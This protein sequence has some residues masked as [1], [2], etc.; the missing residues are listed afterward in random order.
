MILH[1]SE[2]ATVCNGSMLELEC[3]TP[4]D[5]LE[6]SFIT[7]EANGQQVSRTRLLST[8]SG[9]SRLQI[10][11]TSFTFSRISAPS[12]LPLM[13]RLLISPTY[14]TLNGTVFRCEDVA[15]SDSSTTLVYVT[16]EDSVHDQ[17]SFWNQY[18]PLIVYCLN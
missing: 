6:W 4:E 9:M 12:S 5:L 11:L 2:S 18:H 13:S 1:P 3:T 10:N 16:N 7:R 15:S 8:L 14:T 17:G